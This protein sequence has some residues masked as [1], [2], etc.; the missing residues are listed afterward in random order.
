MNIVKRSAAFVRP[1]SMRFWTGQVAMICATLAGLVFP[2]VTKHL[3]DNLLVDKDAGKILHFVGI[4]AATFMVMHMA[5]YIK[6]LTLGS[7]SHKLVRDLRQAL[8]E[9][10]QR[11][12]FAYLDEKGSGPI[13]SV[14]TNDINLFQEAL[15]SG[16]VWILTQMLALVGILV[17]LFRLDFSLTI[18]LAAVAPFMILISIFMGRRVRKT[19]GKVQEQLGLITALINESIRGFDVI[20]TYV[21]R[22]LA[23]SDFRE[24]NRRAAGESVRAVKIKALNGVLV[25]VLGTIFILLLIGVGGMHVFEGQISAG[26]LVAYMVYAEMIIGPLG[27]LSG[28]YMEVQKAFAAGNRIFAFLDAQEEHEWPMAYRGN[29]S[30][31]SGDVVLDEERFVDSMD[32]LNA[33]NHSVMEKPTEP[34][35]KVTKRGRNLAPGI[36]YQNVHFSYAQDEPVI[37]RFDLSVPSGNRVAFVGPSGGGKST[38][39]KLLLRFYEPQGGSIDLGG[40]D[41]RSLGL[42]ELRGRIGA[43]MQETHLFDRTVRE[44]ILVG[45]PLASDKEVIRAAKAANA[46]EFIKG[47]PQG[48][49][50]MIGENGARLSGGQRQRISIARAFLKD[51]EVILLDEAT[52]SLDS[53]SEKLIHHSLNRLMKERTSLV[54][55]HRLSTIKD[56]DK[57]VLIDSG[58]IRGMGTHQELFEENAQYRSLCEQQM[59]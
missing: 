33:E 44:N 8:F 40:V 25:G 5:N 55:A 1:Y 20:K 58:E 27:M 4:L 13:V 38:L 49:D 23:V 19:H 39:F 29:R 28:L 56:A 26:D 24:E 2:F 35:K 22:S 7:L 45:N 21:L 30:T 59:V 18:L 16:V 53:R 50:T 32:V 52:A 47:M 57:I 36:E 51:P 11:L 6:D 12:P 48:Y 54:I 14:M 37:H 31:T 42:E 34:Q 15:A 17:M 43:V 9:K 10:L 41:I 46:H 3:I